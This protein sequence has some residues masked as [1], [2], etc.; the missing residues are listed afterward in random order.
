MKVD[1]IITLLKDVVSAQS[2][3]SGSNLSEEDTKRKIIEPFFEAF[4]WDFSEY[5]QISIRMNDAITHGKKNDYPDYTFKIRDDAVLVVEA[6]PITSSLTE[7]NREQ[8][9]RYM[10]L[11]DSSFG[12]LTNGLKFEFYAGLGKNID[13]EQSLELGDKMALSPKLI[14]KLLWLHRDV[15]ELG[16]A[17]NANDFL[18]LL[19]GY[20]GFE[21]VN[22]AFD[23]IVTD[24]PIEGI[25][26]N[27]TSFPGRAP[28]GA[29]ISSKEYQEP[30]LRI[31]TEKN[32]LKGSEIIDKIEK[33]FSDRFSQWDYG[34]LKRGEIRWKSRVW[35]ALQDLKTLEKIKLKEG[36]YSLL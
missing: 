9:K 15:W 26:T 23:E 3:L 6:K 27:Q 34:H 8:L 12:I 18:K 35:F 7:D 13:L 36:R 4:G 22:D 33:I 19:N 17:L 14:S 31:L 1:E 21:I 11:G 24:N 32:G 20:L 5:G 28:V 2:D 16:A 29:A 10:K 25:E 30:I